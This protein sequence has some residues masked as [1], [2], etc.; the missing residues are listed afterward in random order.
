VRIKNLMLPGTEGGLTLYKN[1]KLP[2]YE[3]AMRYIADRHADVIFGG[4]EYGTGSSRDWAAK[5]T[6]LLGVRAVIARK[7]RAHPPLEP[8]RHGRAAAAVHRN[9]LG[10]QPRHQ[11]D[12]TVDVLGLDH[13]EPQQE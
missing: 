6:Q 8:G 2:I 4:E 7:L 11:G 13:I 1:Q 10:G 9:R 3:A 5:G 12:E